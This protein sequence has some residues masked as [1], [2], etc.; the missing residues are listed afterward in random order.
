M[1]RFDATEPARKTDPHPQRG[2]REGEGANDERSSKNLGES[3]LTVMSGLE[4]IEPRTAVQIHGIKAKPELNGKRG[5]VMGYAPERMR[6]R[7]RIDAGEG[8][9]RKESEE[10]YL[11]PE[12]EEW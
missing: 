12:N 5:M 11:K 9:G 1:P 2:T 10:V 3:L 8:T 7:V 4:Y 6:Y